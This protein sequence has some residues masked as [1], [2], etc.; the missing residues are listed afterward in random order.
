MAT[1]LDEASTDLILP[2]TGMT[3]VMAG[4]KYRLTDFLQAA[5]HLGGQPLNLGRD[6]R[7]HLY[8]IYNNP[9]NSILL[10]FA[11]QTEK[12]SYLAYKSVGTLT[13]YPYMHSLYVAPTGNQVSVFSNDKVATAMR[14]SRIIQKFYLNT[15]TKDQVAYKE[16]ANGS[17]MY[18]RSA[19]LT[20]D[21]SRGISS[22][23]VTFDECQ[24]ILS[25]HIAVIEQSMAHS[26]EKW[27]MFRKT[28]P[29]HLFM[30][31]IYAG[32]PK[33][34]ENTLEQLWR[35]S[36]QTEWIIKCLHCNRFNYIDDKNIGK[37]FL[38]CRK[39]GKDIHYENGNWYQFN[40][41][42]I[43]NGFRMPQIVLPWINDRKDPYKWQKS[44][45]E[46][47]QLYNEQKFHN[48]ILA[49]PYASATNPISAVHVQTCCKTGQAMSLIP[50]KPGTDPD[51]PT[52]LIL[53]VDWGKGDVLAQGTSFTNINIAG[54]I[55][56][57]R[58]RT[59]YAKKFMGAETDPLV[60]IQ[61]IMRLVTIFN[62][63]LVVADHGD[64]R[65]SNAMLLKEL[66]PTRFAEVYSSHSSGK[67]IKWDPTGKY[68]INRTQMMTDVIMMVRQ[69]AMRW[70]DYEDFKK[71]ARDML[72]IYADYS[73]KT[74]MTR[75]DHTAPDDYFHALM[76]TYIGMCLRA[77]MFDKYLFG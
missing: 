52:T 36:T 26:L 27:E 44:V 62:V 50:P 67:K 3:S 63:N 7:R 55:R 11:R 43:I 35:E 37:D 20:A 60:E 46:T 29:K 38:I 21:S 77:G 2:G 31:K 15:K 42:G 32:T 59:V 57:N 8:H 16:M 10:K 23:M 12:S 69:G 34:V 56:G 49:L 17:K 76:Y 40:P 39:C 75:Y 25:D 19:Y 51:W 53:G 65:T 64:G 28:H 24:D 74:R 9:Y 4:H 1:M 41:G 30:S 58:M 54:M 71:F 70:W 14:E 13:R 22:D 66:G 47:R 18:Y 61:E 68:I 73:D 45:I 6:K 72:A 5:F 33:T 48:E